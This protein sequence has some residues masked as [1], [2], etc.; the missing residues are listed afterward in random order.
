MKKVLSI[1][2]IAVLSTLACNKADNPFYGEKLK[3]STTKSKIE[4]NNEKVGPG[5]WTPWIY[6]YYPNPDGSFNCK[7]GGAKNCQLWIPGIATMENLD[8]AINSGPEALAEFFLYEIDGTELEFIKDD[9]EVYAKFT[10]GELLAQKIV[11]E[12]RI[13]YR[14][15]EIINKNEVNY[16]FLK[17]EL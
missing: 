7:K 14:F 1:L 13:M 11:Y 16:K 17:V 5:H 9:R 3:Q 2:S 12:D 8:I 10:S 15:F 4:N 6:E